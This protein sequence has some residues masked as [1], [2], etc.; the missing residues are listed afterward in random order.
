MSLVVS[1]PNLSNK[2]LCLFKS[3]L[4]FVYNYERWDT[5]RRRTIKASK[6]LRAFVDE[7]SF[8]RLP[9][10]FASEHKLVQSNIYPEC[11]IKFKSSLRMNQISVANE[12]LK[13]LESNVGLT[14]NLHTSFGK[15]VLSTYLMCNLSMLTLVTYTSKTGKK[16][17]KSTIENMTNATIWIIGEKIPDKCNVILSTVGKIKHI[18][19]DISK[20]IGLVIIDESD[21]FCTEKRIGELL[22]ISPK[23]VIACTATVERNDNMEK[24][25]YSICSKKKISRINPIK[26]KLYIYRTGIKFDT[27]NWKEALDFISENEKRNGKIVKLIKSNPKHKFLI[28][29]WRVNHKD[30][31]VK[32]LK[33]KNINHDWMS[34]NRKTYKDSNVL[35]GTVSKIGRGFDEKSFCDSF[36]GVAIDVLVMVGSTKSPSLAIQI[37]GRVMRSCRPKIVYFLDN[38]RTSEK[39]LN[40]FI[41]SVDVKKLIEMDSKMIIK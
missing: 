12:A 25:M 15:T 5:K 38:T 17:W 2:Q 13:I 20:Y 24:A 33:N 19:E 26:P 39:H 36:N 27:S 14:L 4:T 18:P 23:K 37:A 40:A 3:K 21:T 22:K 31:I 35:V 16:Q 1:K 29:T 34:G 32:M 9:L 28:L 7:G 41:D 11:K 30:E 8:V 6:T 10:S